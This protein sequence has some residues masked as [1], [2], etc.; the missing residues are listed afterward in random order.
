MLPF[1]PLEFAPRK[2]DA[3]STGFASSKDAKGRPANARLYDHQGMKLVLSTAEP[4]DGD[5]LERA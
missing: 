3:Y 4:G 1:S 2:K 5:E